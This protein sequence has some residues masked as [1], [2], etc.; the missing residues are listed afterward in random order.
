M[1]KV[2]TLPIRRFITAC[3]SAVSFLSYDFTAFLLR[4]SFPLMGDTIKGSNRVCPRLNVKSQ[5]E[6]DT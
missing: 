4:Y 5:I 3:A 1:D 6:V 2:V